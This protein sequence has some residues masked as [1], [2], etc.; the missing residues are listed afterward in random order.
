MARYAK[1]I[2]VD[3]EPDLVEA[4]A[5]YLSAL[6]HEVRTASSAAA[7]DA[8]L[9]RENAD[10]IV[11]DVN[12][13]G[14]NGL[15]YLRR[16]RETRSMPV[17]VLTGN[18]DTIDRVIGLELGAD[19]FVIKPCDPQELAA[20]VAGLLGRYKVATRE[21]VQFEHATVDLTASRLLRIGQPPERL[22]PGEVMLVRVFAARPNLL[23]KRD[24]LMDLAPAESHEA[25]DRAIDTRIARLRRKLGTEAIVTVRGHGYMFVPPGRTTP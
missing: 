20:R 19:D 1:L 3:D 18:P 2:L 8:L 6:G 15:D 14:E 24:E 17:L 21:V 4:Y 16:L 23:L 5:D 13:P 9:E 25:N 22:G 10:L 7:C 12:I 11:L